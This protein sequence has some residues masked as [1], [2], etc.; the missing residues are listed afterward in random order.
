VRGF[1]RSGGGGC[2]DRSASPPWRSWVSRGNG[3]EAG[4]VLAY[5]RARP[6]EGARRGWSQAHRDA[7]SGGYPLRERDLRAYDER[8]GS[9]VVAVFRETLSGIRKGKGKRPVGRRRMI[10]QARHDAPDLM[11]RPLAPVSPPRCI[12]P[13]I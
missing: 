7:G 2:F 8:A 1:L 5:A 11:D 6:K 12:P 13:E 4:G 9:E 3:G 10:V